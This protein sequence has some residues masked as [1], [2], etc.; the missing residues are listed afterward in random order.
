MK[1]NKLRNVIVFVLVICLLA[2]FASCG[3]SGG[4]GS[5]TAGGN[6]TTGGNTSVNAPG[7]GDWTHA[8]LGSAFG[9]NVTGTLTSSVAEE[10]DIFMQWKSSDKASF[11]DTVI[12]LQSN[13]YNQFNGS[14]AE[15]ENEGGM[16]TYTAEKENAGGKT[17]VAEVVYITKDI[18]IA[19]QSFKAGDLYFS[20]EEQTNVAPPT[21][22]GTA[23]WPADKI[24]E[25]LGAPIPAYT[26]K[27][28]EF[29]FSNASVGAVKNIAVTAY[30][31]DAGAEASYTALLTSEGYTED[32][33]TY[34][35][36]LAN[37]DKIEL[38]VY[39]GQTMHPGTYQSVMSLQIS[40]L[41]V[42]NSGEYT[43]WNKLN[44]S[45]F[46]AVIPA[47]NGGTSFDFTNLTEETKK[48]QLSGL[49]QAIDILAAYENMLDDAQKAE[50]AALR[51]KV[52]YIE[53]IEAAAIIIYG[54]DNDQ[55]SAY[56]D[57]LYSAGFEGGEKNTADFKYTVDLSG[58]DENGKASI[59][60]TKMPQIFFE[61]STGGGE[62]E[63][64]ASYTMP[65]NVK[66]VYTYGIQGAASSTYTVIKVGEDYY[67]Q[68][69]VSGIVFEE[70]YYKKN[71]G[72]WDVYTK[73]YMEEGW[74][75]DS[76]QENDK[77]YLERKVFD[78][79]V[80]EAGV[81][82][83]SDA[84]KGGTETVAGRTTDVYTQY[85]NTKYCKDTETGLILKYSISSGGYALE[86]T[87]TSFDTSVTSFDGITLPQ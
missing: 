68:Q 5:T 66:I 54:T 69:L 26:G 40:V 87:V 55:I 74:S 25:A 28:N 33:G 4:S 47:F 6:G 80:K 50:L 10:G 30:G 53:K 31:V 7:A 82:G 86:Y 21:Q 51:E 63:P 36:V 12:W 49:Q 9:A 46:G 11:D 83:Y 84:E 61:E 39:C 35:K 45:A 78:F 38:Y 19:N 16:F 29:V 75:K 23:T 59:T 77:S 44:L 22:G 71:G 2:V 52:P 24:L 76:S 13:G 37:G 65:E 1:R 17:M 15:V 3:G 57:A 58:V 34:T 60:F 8:G 32:E 42:K 18:S 70:Q 43:A 62:E 79:I 41:Y 85:G 81:S 27:A 72:D 67:A 48:S 64:D 14:G 56:W 20:V 73:E